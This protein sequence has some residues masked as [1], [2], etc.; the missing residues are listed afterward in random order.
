MEKSMKTILANV[1]TETLTLHKPSGD[2]FEVAGLVD[3]DSSTVFSDDV[4]IPIEVND[5]FERTLPN[6]VVEYYKVLDAGFYK[7]IHGIPDNYQTKVQQIQSPIVYSSENNNRDKMIF[8]SH[9]SKDKE[10]TKAFVDLLFA[11][12]L[13]DE[14]IVCSSYPGLGVPLSNSIYEWLVAKFQECDLHVLYFLS[15]NYYKSAASLNEMGAAWAMK[16]KWDG[17]LL[18][19]FNF[20]DITGCIDATK[21]GIKMDGDL[22]E[23]KHRLGEIKDRIVNEFALRPVSATRWERMRDTFIETISRI[24]YKSSSDEKPDVATA[25]VHNGGPISIFACVMLM[26]AAESNGQIMVIRSISGTSYEA[27]N[28]TMQRSQSPRE[29]A[30]WDDAVSRLIANGYIMR[31]DSKGVFYQVTATGYNVA[32][33]FK[34]DN[35]LD[36]NMSP[37]E[38]LMKFSE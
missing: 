4:T 33:S 11:I 25:P 5:Y 7:G 36:I 30:K 21:I 34:Q 35:E 27:G 12:G 16:Q 1:P 9:S 24:E 2:V 37:S 20:S 17:I 14:D 28:T 8:I 13:N 10:Y 6:G 23:L 38:I 32:D 31:V 3:S 26:Y 19:G 22:D 18:P 29:L 15:H